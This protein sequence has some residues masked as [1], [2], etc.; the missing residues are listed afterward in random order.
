M[1]SSD[2]TDALVKPTFDD[3]DKT[4]FFKQ[5]WWKVKIKFADVYYFTFNRIFQQ[6]CSN[7]LYLYNI[8]EFEYFRPN[9]GHVEEAPHSH[10][11]RNVELFLT[12]QPNYM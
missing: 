6:R 4:V 1:T 9:E 10:R 12:I 3:W 11:T 7:V 8:I 2:K 5:K